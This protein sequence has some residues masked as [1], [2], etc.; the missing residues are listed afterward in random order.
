MFIQKRKT[1]HHHNHPLIALR[2]HDMEKFSSMIVI[3]VA[4]VELVPLTKICCGSCAAV[5]TGRRVLY[6][7]IIMRARWCRWQGSNLSGA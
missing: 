6:R 3:M 1:K 4:V 2:Q 5:G 7:P